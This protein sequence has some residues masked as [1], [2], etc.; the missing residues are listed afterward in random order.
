MHLQLYLPIVVLFALSSN[1]GAVFVRRRASECGIVDVC[2]TTSEHNMHSI[3]GV[4]SMHLHRV[5]HAVLVS[6]MKLGH[7]LCFEASSTLVGQ[8]QVL[9][10]IRLFWSDCPAAAFWHDIPGCNKGRIMYCVW[11]QSRAKFCMEVQNAMLPHL[12]L[13]SPR[14]Q[15]TMFTRTLSVKMLAKPS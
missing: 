10:D 7:A 12:F 8:Q 2:S 3:T 11:C 1:F 9:F 6:F 5:I 15:S 13:V 4:T 14:W